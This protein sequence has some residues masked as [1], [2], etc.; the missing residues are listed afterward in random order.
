MKNFEKYFLFILLGFLYGNNLNL[1]P[2]FLVLNHFDRKLS[3]AD[4]A[5]KENFSNSIFEFDST[6]Y[7]LFELCKYVLNEF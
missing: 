5:L 7:L 3:M 1:R 2:T 4:D 6:F